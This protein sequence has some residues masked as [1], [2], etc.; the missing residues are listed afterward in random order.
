[1]T[2]QGTDELT[3]ISI[4]EV[5]AAGLERLA[6][7]L[8]SDG[9]D[10]A[11]DRIRDLSKRLRDPQKTLRVAL[12]GL[13]SA[14]K[15]SLINALV[16]KTVTATGAVPT[17][18]EI[19]EVC[20][21]TPQGRII[22]MDTPGIDS[23]DE[24]HGQVTEA[25][26]HMADVVCLVVDYSHVESEETL[27]FGRMLSER[28]VPLIVVVHQIDKH[29]E[30]ELGFD[31]FARRVEATL[32]DY[33][34]N[35]ISIY[36]TS[37]ME[38]PHNERAAWQNHLQGMA[39][40]A[41]EIVKN[42]VAS[43]AY[44][45]VRQAAAEALSDRRFQVEQE[46]QEALG[47]LPLDS[48]E[49]QEWVAHLTD[50]LVALREELEAERQTV[51][52]AYQSATEG[53]HR[54]I[55]LGQI[56]PYDTTERGRMFVESLRKG[57]KV[58]WL[59]AKKRT[60]DEQSRRLQAFAQALR[61]HLRQSL[62]WPLQRE[63]RSFVYGTQLTSE[64]WL[65]SLDTLDVDVP[66][67]LF[68]DAVNKGALDSTQYPYQYVK[69]V[70]GRVKT[71]VKTV[72]HQIMKSWHDDMMTAFA[73]AHQD[74]EQTLR[75]LQSQLDALVAYTSLYDEERAMVQNYIDVLHT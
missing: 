61:E 68:Y 75:N 57:F 55:D 31:A 50:R 42:S 17:T 74:E 2:V 69:E 7:A 28:D 63:I 16:G 6:D 37:L 54:S 3:T 64:Q 22:L 14:G 27:E 24:A 62:V 38:S 59:N 19:H 72:L 34:M 11:G 47:E 23:T 1:M 40:K 66:H 26:L 35:E 29:L 65:T 15:S 67:T 70:V 25:A 53:F 71:S 30:F 8:A 41:S 12:C 60:E 49:A 39:A 51:E 46:T 73:E 44:S 45:V 4:E 10:E 20:W 13:F 48:A 18:A 32:A 33:G 5:N 56:A 21:D 43:N 9:L 36:Y 52:A 58:G